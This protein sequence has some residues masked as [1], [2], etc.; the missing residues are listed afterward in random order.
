MNCAEIILAGVICSGISGLPT[1]LLSATSGFGQKC[2]A[3]LNVAGCVLGLLGVWTY[4]THSD[5]VALSFASPVPGFQFTANLDGLSAF[6]LVPV[7]LVCGLAS[8]Y[9]VQYWP[10]D[11]GASNAQRVSVFLGLMTAGIMV[12][13]VA[14]DGLLFLFGWET[15][16]VSAY[17]LVAA[18]DH[19]AET[20][21][22]AWLYMAASHF[23]TLS[24]F[25]VFA[26]LYSQTGSFSYTILPESGSTAAVWMAVL[27][28][29][30]FGT[31]AGIMPMHIWLPGAHAAAP[32]HVSAVMSGVVIK[33]GIY[34][35]FRTASFFPHIPL[36]W[37]LVTL[38]LGMISA[39]LGI[40]FAVS[41]R[42]FKR[43]LAY[44]SIE[45]IGIIV[46]GLG[47]ALIGRATGHAEWVMLGLCG[48]LLHVWNHAIFKSMLFMCAGSVIHSMETRQLD[49]MGGLS[50]R[51]PATATC[52]VIGAVAICGLPPL[53]G[54]VSELLIYLGLFRTIHIEPDRPISIASA[55]AFAAPGLALVGALAVACFVKVYG[56]VFLGAARS[57]KAAHAH[58]S[59]IAMTIPMIILAAC[60]VM[61]GIAPLAVVPFVSKA[62]LTMAAAEIHNSA[63][64]SEL[65]LST[66]A[67][68]GAMS[69]VAVILIT[70]LSIGTFVLLRRVRTSPSSLTWDCGYAAPSAK[71]QYT[72]SSFAQ[73]LVELFA[74]ALRP[75]V[76]QP[77][78][79]SPF[80]E[81]AR[82]ESHVSD[83]VLEKIINPTTQFLKWLFGLSRYLQQGS[84]QAYLLYIFLI[85][86]GLLL[87]Q[88]TG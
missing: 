83:T 81:N 45:N 34:G 77:K 40:V 28:L 2:A 72:S 47:L 64:I 5:S 51:M 80:P 61:I 11:K 25:G 52:F 85:V 58:E 84:L 75:V 38:A 74:W 59:G 69:I 44:S 88:P 42:D 41:Q 12:V 86:L 32:S 78:L 27:G 53:N 16:A 39:V 76:Q 21:K 73:W 68:L 56:I 50:R 63:D 10:Q 15:M 70:L 46:M 87:W 18:E 57:E 66:L 33:M 7:C 14:A 3:L 55:A 29:I 35:M 30:G 23:A 13:V 79:E 82:F 17:F 36:S 9:G 54:F 43:L 8:V 26:I 22:A 62:A 24:A 1:L 4:H 67:P 37:G 65:S 19:I 20:R 49:V 48:A 60:C 6:F 71:M 31:K